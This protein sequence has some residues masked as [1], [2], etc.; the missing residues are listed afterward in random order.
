LGCTYNV[1]DGAGTRG[2]I[3]FAQGAC[4]GAFRADSRIN[5]PL[6]H[7]RLLNELQPHLQRMA[8][9][10]TLQYLLDNVCGQVKPVI[11]T[12]FWTDKSGVIVSPHDY[13]QFMEKGGQLLER[14]AMTYSRSVKAWQEYYDMSDEQ[15]NLMVSLFRRRL[16]YPNEPIILSSE[17]LAL[18]GDN[19]KGL[20]E[21]RASFRELNILF[22][23]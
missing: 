5:E 21:S 1:Q 9:D 20:M 6:D 16:S 12:T 7:E 18:L 3:S 2:T 22:N 15:V 19:E 13:L 8:Y 11:T 14:Q 17:E 23:I 10:E 4:I